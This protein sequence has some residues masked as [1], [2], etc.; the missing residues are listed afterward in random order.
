MKKSTSHD[1]HEDTWGMTT[2]DSF[3]HMVRLPVRY[4]PETHSNGSPEK[5]LKQSER[6][7]TSDV[8]P[9]MAS[10]KMTPEIKR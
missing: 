8:H 3:K 9:S 6:K 10:P 4:I 5:A 1:S 7:D 2:S